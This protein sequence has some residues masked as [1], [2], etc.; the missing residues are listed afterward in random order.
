MRRAQY[1]IPTVPLLIIAAVTLL[2]N[3]GGARRSRALTVKR[4][5]QDYGL[6]EETARGALQLLPER[7]PGHALERVSQPHLHGR[8]QGSGVIEDEDTGPGRFTL[9]RDVEFSKI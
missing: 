5:M 2:Y 6:S 3:L 1:L 8:P 4:L 7:E 9:W